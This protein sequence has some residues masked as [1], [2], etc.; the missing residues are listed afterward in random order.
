MCGAPAATAS[1]GHG[2]KGS[3]TRKVGA[4]DRCGG[5]SSLKSPRFQVFGAVWVHLRMLLQVN[6]CEN[7]ARVKFPNQAGF[8]AP[9]CD[10]KPCLDPC[11][12]P[13]MGENGVSRS[14]PV[15]LPALPGRN[16]P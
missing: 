11:W 14:I 9:Q 10:H 6:L 15:A 16:Q 5:G 3:G 12:R 2:P 8:A 7:I 13:G 4:W 1:A